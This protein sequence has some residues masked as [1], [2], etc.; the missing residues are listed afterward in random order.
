MAKKSNK[1][2]VE[3]AS[4]FS[5]AQEE[6]GFARGS[7]YPDAIHEDTAAAREAKTKAVEVADELYAL[8]ETTRLGEEDVVTLVGP[9]PKANI[10]DSQGLHFVDGK[11]EGV[12]KSVADK[13]VADLEGYSIQGK[14]SK[15]ES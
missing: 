10:V 8:D 2:R 14:S 11:A 4:E 12:P 6:E 7:H 5:N 1:S 13:Y 9:N 3:V 15:S